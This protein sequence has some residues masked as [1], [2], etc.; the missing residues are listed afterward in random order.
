MQANRAD[1]RLDSAHPRLMLPYAA[2]L[3]C[4]PAVSDGI[5]NLWASSLSYLGAS[6]RRLALQDNGNLVLYDAHHVVLWETGTAGA[7]DQWLGKLIA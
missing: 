4:L 7:I 1:S 2:H 6:P 5:E 3:Y